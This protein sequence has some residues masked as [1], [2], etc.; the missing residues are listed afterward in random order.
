MSYERPFKRNDK[1]DFS[2]CIFRMLTA[3][4]FGFYLSKCE[5][6][7]GTGMSTTLDWTFHISEGT[8]FKLIPL[9]FAY[10]NFL[11]V[12]LFFVFICKRKQKEKSGWSYV[13]LKIDLSRIVDPFLWPTGLGSTSQM[14][15]DLLSDPSPIQN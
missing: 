5:R 13:G 9:S 11:F 2:P 15:R 12:L 3:L 14:G 4:N 6:Q 7:G 10:L 1:I 8:V